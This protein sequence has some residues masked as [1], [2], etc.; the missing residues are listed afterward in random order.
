MICM[1]FGI[2]DHLDASGVPVGQLY[3]ERLALIEQAEALGFTRYQVAEHHGTPLGLAPSPSI[4]LAS[5]I[6]HTTTMRVGALVYVLPLYSPLRLAEEIGQLDQLS[7]GRLEVG[8]GRGAS[9]YELGFY[10]V[11]VSSTFDIY[12]ESLAAITSALTAGAMTHT[13]PKLGSIDAPLV[14]PVVQR[15]Y[16]PLWFA[17]S[18]PQSAAWAGEQGMNLIGFG[19]GAGFRPSVDQYWQSWKAHATD[20]SRLN[21]HVAHPLVGVGRQIV[22]A[23]TDDEAVRLA[24]E[25]HATHSENFLKLWHENG[26]FTRDGM[27]DIEKSLASGMVL[28]GSPATVCEQVRA[29]IA[30]SGIN[31]LMCTFAFG[32]LSYD[33]AARSM[34]LFAS[35][36]MPGLDLE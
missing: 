28:A 35:D 27:V 4:W 15:P 22:I 6:Q 8:V 10:G 25:A 11:D 19:T 9:P 7:G 34:N 24:R 14:I 30:D 16:P 12:V 36:V 13:G 21:A 3:R 31:Y 5:V 33:N 2:F 17:S 18:N 29:L 32:S 23:P 26:N 1:E 20:S